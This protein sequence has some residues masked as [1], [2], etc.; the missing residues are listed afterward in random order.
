M[1]K[2]L[3]PQ[4][5]ETVYWDVLPNG[6]TLAVVPRPGFTKKLAYFVTDFGSI[7]TKFQLEGESRQ[8]QDGIAHF[9]EHKLFDLPDR[10]VSEEFAALGASPNAFTSY[11]LTAYYFGC[12]EHFEE[13]LALLL[14]FVSTPYFTEQTVEKEQGIIGQ[15][16]DMNRDNPDS[17]AFELL[18]EAMYGRHPIRVPILGTRESLAGI[19]PAQLQLCHQ[20]FYRPGNMLL[21]VAGDVDPE[22]V[23]AIALQQ[24]PAQDRPAAQVAEDWEEPVQTLQPFV[25]A[26]MEVA[27]PMFQLGFKCEPTGRGTDAI[28]QEIIGQLAAEALL[29]ESSQLYLELYQQGLIDGSFGGGFESIQGMAMLSAGGDSDEPE[30]VRDAILAHARRLVRDG[31]D[32]ADF[33]RMKR[34]A[35]GQRIRALDSF[36]ALCFRLCAYHF[37]AFDYLR[38]PEI[39]AQ[40][41]ENDV[42]EFLQRVVQPERMSLCVIYPNQ[43]E[44]TQ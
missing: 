26:H 41:T 11:D 12:T 5:G 16:I 1:E 4:L 9:L 13:S 38:F 3:Y 7:H 6:L 33:L 22:R 14:E 43:E 34:S 40:I 15:E 32:P 8:V 31:L 23:R 2:R 21:C 25:S 18:A 29:G 44:E 39:Y 19:T 24:L 10:D 30:A 37:A 28:R 36:D 35:L 20:A 17:R 27:M 42:L